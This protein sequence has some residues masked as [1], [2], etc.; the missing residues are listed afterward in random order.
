MDVR[1]V[2]LTFFGVWG[3]FFSVAGSWVVKGRLSGCQQQFCNEGGEAGRGQGSLQGWR[4]EWE[5]PWLG[6][7]ERVRLGE[8]AGQSSGVPSSPESWVDLREP[9]G[10]KRAMRPRC[11][12]RSESLSNVWKCPKG[13]LQKGTL[14]IC[15][16]LLEL[17]ES[18]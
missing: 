1:V 16:N 14:R 17:H 18:P 9:S 4:S 10:P 13:T 2:F 5:K 3:F 6:K 12:T 8:R 11:V 7:S 15:L